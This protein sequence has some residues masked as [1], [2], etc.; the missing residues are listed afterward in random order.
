M[1]A[2]R[3][4]VILLL[5]GPALVHAQ[6]PQFSQFYASSQYLN[7][8]L[9]GNTFQDRIALNYRLQ[10]PGVQPGFET[11]AFA[12]DHNFARAHS[13]LGGLVVRDRAGSYGLSFTTIAMSY[14]YEARLDRRRAL[15]FGFRT[16]YTIRNVAPDGYLFADQIIRDN[17][18]TSIE[19]NMVPHTGYL[20][21]AT[22]ALYYSE[23]FWAGFSFNHINRPNQTL[24]VDGDAPLQMRMTFHTGYRFALDG[25]KLTRSETKMTIAGHYKAQGKWDQ[26][27]LGGYIEHNRISGGLWY[28]GLPLFKAYQQG[29]SNS[30]SVILMVGFETE[31]QLRFVYSYDITIS[32]LTLKSAGAHEISMIYEW[33]RRAKARRH[34]VVPCPKF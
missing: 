14:S 12:Y 13:G 5:I 4:L 26:L 1:K 6:D 27:D 23:Q 22:G 9:T 16:G 11:Y 28:R 24:M 25:H 10:W 32:K 29:Y 31:K 15:R 33:P 7:P 30:E 2:L 3:L 34:K 20:D 21:L 17:A 18:P 8:A 19:A